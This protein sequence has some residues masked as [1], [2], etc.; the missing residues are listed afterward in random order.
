MRNLDLDAYMQ[1]KNSDFIDWGTVPRL[2]PKGIKWLNAC[3]NRLS[4]MVNEQ[5]GWDS[6]VKKMAKDGRDEKGI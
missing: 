5:G 4:E 3:F 6:A 1:R 2:T